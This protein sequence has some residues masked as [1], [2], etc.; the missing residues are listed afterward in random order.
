[1]QCAQQMQQGKLRLAAVYNPPITPIAKKCDSCGKPC[2]S[3]C[4]C[5]E[6]FC[7]RACMRRDWGEHRRICETVFE[8][9]GA[10]STFMTQAEMK[11]RL[12]DAELQTALGAPCAAKQPKALARGQ[13]AAHGTEDWRYVL[14]Q[15]LR[16]RP[17]LNG[18]PLN[19]DRNQ[20]SST[21]PPM[22]SLQT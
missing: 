2:Q 12:T 8:S 6:A 11:Q 18:V 17:E 10:L 19:I 15:G 16:A 4:M 3:E 5:G 9:N 14:L 21:K 13:R 1:M 22:L 7:S 20:N